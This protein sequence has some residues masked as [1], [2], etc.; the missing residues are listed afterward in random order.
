LAKNV[1][2]LLTR[3]LFRAFGVKKPKRNGNCINIHFYAWEMHSEKN[4]LFLKKSSVRFFQKQPVFFRKQPPPEKM[5]IYAVS[6]WP[7]QS[8]PNH[9][10]QSLKKP[11][12]LK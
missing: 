2:I 4:R 5:H 11:A 8:R 10:S 3:S 9:L 1:K 6:E 12:K 7:K